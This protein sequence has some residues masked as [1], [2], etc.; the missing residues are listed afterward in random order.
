M[1]VG[2]PVFSFCSVSS[3]LPAHALGNAVGINVSAWDFASTWTCGESAVH[4]KER[5]LL[6]IW[7]VVASELSDGITGFWVRATGRFRGVFIVGILW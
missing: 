3:P 5:M 1:S 6:F 2:Q 7:S 4:T